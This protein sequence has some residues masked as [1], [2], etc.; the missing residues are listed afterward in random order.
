MSAGS[1]LD[2]AFVPSP[3]Y[4]RR[5]ATAVNSAYPSLVVIVCALVAPASLHPLHPL[6]FLTERRSPSPSPDSS[7]RQRRPL[8]PPQLAAR[9]ETQLRT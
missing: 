5:P 9:A 8:R 1:V 4:T 3:A 2:V 6:D 7:I